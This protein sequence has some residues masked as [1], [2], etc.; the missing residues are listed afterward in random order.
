MPAAAA[1]LAAAAV[2][3]R[4]AATAEAVAATTVEILILI[5]GQGRSAAASH[6][7]GCSNVRHRVEAAAQQR[8]CKGHAA[9]MQMRAAADQSQPHVCLPTRS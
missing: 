5:E 8:L 9:P 7:K 2:V 3:G 6:K 4:E 1:M